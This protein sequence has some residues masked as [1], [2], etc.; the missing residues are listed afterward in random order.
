[1]IYREN[2]N[3]EIHKFAQFD[4]QILEHR[5]KLIRFYAPIFVLV[6]RVE[7]PPQLLLL[8]GRKIELLDLH[9]QQNSPTKWLAAGVVLGQKKEEQQIGLFGYPR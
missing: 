7:V 8:L 3:S 5:H 1:M 6:E 4:T 9:P 2:A